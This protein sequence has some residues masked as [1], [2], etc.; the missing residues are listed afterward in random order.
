MSIRA[1]ACH[2]RPSHDYSLGDPAVLDVP[3]RRA[4]AIKIVAMLSQAEHELWADQKSHRREVLSC[5]E[6]GCS[7]G[8]ITHTLATRY[9]RTVG[10]DVDYA[11]LTHPVARTLWEGPGC[12]RPTLASGL[13]LP[14]PAASF[15]IVVCNQVYQYVANVG[16]LLREIHRVLA[17]GGLC[18]F[19]ARNLWGV[20]SPQNLRPLL[21]HL[22]PAA[23]RALESRR[24]LSPAWRHRAGDLWPAASLRRLAGSWFEVHDFTA[25]ALTDPALARHFL[26]N[27]R[28]AAALGMLAPLLRALVPLLPTHHWVLSKPVRAAGVVTVEGS[29]RR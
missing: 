28:L 22:A 10:V 17:A 7:A 26:P 12:A 3:S 16:L 1:T 8:I 29:A 23:V 13:A 2:K 4:Q 19:S 9:D 15:D 5:L 27:P 25:R 24:L 20:L 21:S 6:I 14:F 11:A 18:L